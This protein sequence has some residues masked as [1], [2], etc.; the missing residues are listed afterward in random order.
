[1]SIVQLVSFNI[2]I[3]E[4]FLSL[5]DKLSETSRNILALLYQ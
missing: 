1:V 3:S 2:F 4:T 5:F